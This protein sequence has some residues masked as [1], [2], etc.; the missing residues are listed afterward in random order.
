VIGATPGPAGTR[1]AQTAWLPVLR[2]LGT[3]PWYGRSLFLAHAGQAFDERGALT[4]AKGQ[5]LLRDYLAGFAAF[6]T[7][8]AGAAR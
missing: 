8:H 5:Q 6:V 7:A 4:D 1:L 3:V 2:Q